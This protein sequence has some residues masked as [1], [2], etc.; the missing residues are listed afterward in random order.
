MKSQKKMSTGDIPEQNNISKGI[1]VNL[2][3]PKILQG[4]LFKR[5][6]CTH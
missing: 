6:L 3:M 1:L 2:K 4:K 5:I